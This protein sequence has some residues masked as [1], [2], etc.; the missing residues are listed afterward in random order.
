MDSSPPLWLDPASERIWRG[1]EELKLRP[2]TQAVLRYL[3][4]QAGRVVST[5]ELLTAVWSDVTVR[6]GVLRNCL[7]DLRK[8]L[9]GNARARHYIE[10]VGREGYR[11]CGVV[12]HAPESVSVRESLH[13]SYFVKREM[14]LTV[15]QELLGKAL[16]EQRQLIFLTGEA[17]IGKSSL[18][19]A[20]LARS[21]LSRPGVVAV[22]QCLD[23]HS[24]AEAYLPIL[25]A[26][27]RL[28]RT[29][30]AA[31]I[32][33]LLRQHAPSWLRHLP[34]LLSFE[35]RMKL[36]QEGSSPSSA[37]ILREF[38]LWVEAFTATTTLLLILEDLHWSD[39]S[40][41][42]LIVSLARRQEPAR[43]FL[44]VTARPGDGSR[45]ACPLSQVRH[46]LLTHRLGVELACTPL[47]HDEIIQYIHKR[48]GK[49]SLPNR[50]ARE[51][52][53]RS[54]GHPLFLV[55][56]VDDWITHGVITQTH[57][58]WTWSQKALSSV[59]ESPAFLHDLIA[60]HRR[61]LTPEEQRLLEAASL[62]GMKFSTATVAAA[63]QHDSVAVEEICQNLALHHLMLRPAG[64]EEWPDG[65]V[66]T[67][68]A[69]RYALYQEMWREQTPTG[70]RQ[71][72]QQRIGERLERGYLGHTT[73][74]AAALAFHFAE[75]QD[76]RRAVRYRLQVAETAMRRGAPR[77]ALTQLTLARQSLARWPHSVERDQQELSLLSRLWP[78]MKG[79]RGY[80]AADVAEI[81]NRA[82]TL[83]HCYAPSQ[84]HLKLL[85]GQWAWHF[86][87][88]EL[89]TA[90]RIAR[91]CN[92]LLSPR[93]RTARVLTSE[94]AG[95]MA[96][97]VGAF[98]EARTHLERGSACYHRSQH[99]GLVSLCGQ[100]PGVFCLG[101]GAMTLAVL[102]QHEAALWQSRRAVTLGRQI[103]HPYSLTCALVLAV[104]SRQLGGSADAEV[105]QWADE[106]V[107]HASEH[108]FTQQ[109]GQAL[110]LLGWVM[111]R[112]EQIP[113]GV[114]TLHRGVSTFRETDT[115]LEIPHL[116]GLLAEGFSYAGKLM[117]AHHEVQEALAV[118]ARTGERYY[119]A[120]LYRIC[121][122]V[123]FAMGKAQEGATW[124]RRART[125]A[126]RNQASAFEVRASLSLTQ[127][128]RKTRLVRRFD[129]AS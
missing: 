50:L 34:S 102:G 7:L 109:H 23:H 63:L 39:P 47:S 19:E 129:D 15:L 9:G 119:E 120:E 124:L 105:R 43:L 80:A 32:L 26:L 110:C 76:D 125:I 87:R 68:F 104:W 107:Q 121:G 28:V 106:A 45:A 103:A 85:L 24:V 25:E 69:F 58:H 75:A 62:V 60:T 52:Y 36:E 11:Y 127:K 73:L 116:R 3:L 113:E 61:S 77:E 84:E 81:Y 10:T 51:L 5:T 64:I 83:A 12:R 54:G 82:R 90:Q 20:F 79:M 2:K 30:G 92:R 8:V 49:D 13:S 14:E 88:A 41:L 122:E 114:E 66:A 96:F 31:S 99:D 65:T 128:N 29:L 59:Q 27:D 55:S 53:S 56:L 95:T 70:R 78:L 100:D 115:V 108:G 33:P 111:V 42:D 35:E 89:T 101:Y 94:M 93:L 86:V 46:Y 21:L 118:L 44:L 126:R 74:I 112:Q 17:G 1:T 40:T 22:G 18:L 16:A 71:Q 38:T 117:D 37:R 57:E 4:D 67:R 91:Q 98:A 6:P 97:H 123:L 72:L 48:F